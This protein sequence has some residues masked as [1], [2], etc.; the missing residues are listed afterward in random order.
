MTGKVTALL[1]ESVRITHAHETER[2]KVYFD[3][4][5][6]HNPVHRS[7]DNPCGYDGAYL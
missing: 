4:H 1:S 2:S 5:L 3:E 7:H 6:H